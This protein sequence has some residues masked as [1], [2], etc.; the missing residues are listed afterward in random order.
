MALSKCGVLCASLS[1]ATR[2]STAKIVKQLKGNK[3]KRF[4]FIS[5]RAQSVKEEVLDV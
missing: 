2:I 3:H 1:A 5:E 4:N